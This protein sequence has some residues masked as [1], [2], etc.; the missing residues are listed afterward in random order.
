MKRLLLL[1]ILVTIGQISWAQKKVWD[2]ANMEGQI[3]HSESEFSRQKD[4][5][6]NQAISTATQTASKNQ[7]NTLKQTVKV[8]HARLTNLGGLLADG[9]M[10]LNAYSIVKDILTYED[11]NL[12]ILK[13]EPVLIPLAMQSQS[14]LIDRSKSLITFIELMA[15]SASDLNAM[16]STDRNSIIS[17]VIIQLQTLRVQAIS[18]NKSLIWAENGAAIKSTNPWQGYV[19]VDKKLGLNILNDLKSFKN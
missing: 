4:L 8:I 1:L 17:H 9:K 10:L 16:K 2:I 14:Q 19:N 12:L 3:S 18:L 11:K 15:L 13:S 7:G 6:D 5:R